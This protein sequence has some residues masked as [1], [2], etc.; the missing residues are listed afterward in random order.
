MIIT[1]A[2]TVEELTL[3]AHMVHNVGTDTQIIADSLVCLL[4]IAHQQG[5][6]KIF[7]LIDIQMVCLTILMKLKLCSRET[8]PYLP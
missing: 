6:L 2:E 7:G 5:M 4:Q 3:T 1:I 8:L